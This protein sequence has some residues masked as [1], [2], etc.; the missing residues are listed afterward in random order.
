MSSG[1]FDFENNNVYRMAA[2][3]G[4]RFYHSMIV[5]DNNELPIDLS[6]YT[7]R[8]YV[9]ASH[10]SP[11]TILEMTTVNGRLTITGLSGQI[12]VEVSA[13]DM[14]AI[15]AGIFVYDLEVLPG[16]VEADADRLMEGK[17]QV[18]SEVTK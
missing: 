16:G 2:E 5:R 18:T 1:Y 3:Q 6:G 14:A 7:A 10:D 15:P 11:N 13:V 9:R 17:F 4:S 12:E 8:W